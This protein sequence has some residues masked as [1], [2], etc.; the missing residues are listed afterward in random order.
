MSENILLISEDKSSLE[1]LFSNVSVLQRGEII[2]LTPIAS[3]KKA[4]SQDVK[5]VLIN[6]SEYFYN[7]IFK[8]IEII[9]RANS[10]ICIIVILSKNDDEFV[11][12]CYKNGV[13]DFIN[14]SSSNQEFN[15]RILN[16]LKYLMLKEKSGILSVF[17]NNTSSIN[18]KTGLFTHKSLKENFDNI[19][20][21]YSFFKTGSYIVLSI[22]SS[23]KTKVSMNRLALYLKKYLRQTD[24]IAQGTGKY[25]LLLPRTDLNGAK[26]VVEKVSASM[27]KDIRIHAGISLLDVKDFYELEK[28]ANDSLKSAIVNDKLYVCL[29]EN[30]NIDENV[31]GSLGKNKHFK[32]FEKLFNKKLY[33]LIEPL[34]FRK[35]KEFQAKSGYI[36]VSQY[37]NKVECVFSLRYGEKQSELVLRYD[38]F[39]K[40]NLKIIHKGLDTCENTQ[41]E[42]PLNVLDEKLLTK[43]LH[44]LYNEFNQ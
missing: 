9:K 41:A 26:T 12:E 28:D 42:I 16:C 30:M 34:F 37:A 35:E 4:L 40:F 31:S 39:A 17:L 43:Y 11:A 24:V 8:T 29:G 6:E 2:A 21:E 33:E 25:Y 36:N 27:G 38:G 13:Y 18:A 5:V 23:V 32:L 1:S 7:E 44:L 10:D 20:D 15:V 14:N 22:D 19:C 3:L